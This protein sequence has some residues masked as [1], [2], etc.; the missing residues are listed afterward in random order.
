MRPK[1]R[2]ITKVK[3]ENDGGECLRRTRSTSWRRSRRRGSRRLFDLRWPSSRHCARREVG[4]SC[5]ARRPAPPS[6]IRRLPCSRAAR[7]RTFPAATSCFWALCTPLNLRHQ[8][9][10]RRRVLFKHQHTIIHC[11]YYFRPPKTPGGSNKYKIIALLFYCYCFEL[12]SDVV[13]E[14]LH[15]VYHWLYF[16]FISSVYFDIIQVFDL[17]VIWLP[18]LSPI[19]QWC[20]ISVVIMTAVD[21]RVIKTKWQQSVKYNQK[22]RVQSLGK[23][24]VSLVLWHLIA[25]TVIIQHSEFSCKARLV[26]CFRSS[27]PTMVQSVRPIQSIRIITRWDSLRRVRIRYRCRSRELWGCGT[28]AAAL[29]T[30]G[31]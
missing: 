7:T 3:D 19:L 9:P 14:D 15:R 24:A 23:E 25:G 18:S 2:P 22:H 20:L 21:I 26:M 30:E 4:S 8:S 31:A 10:H 17:T 12:H 11:Y 1:K 16:S 29:S 28:R 5:P 6:P 27:T 13:A